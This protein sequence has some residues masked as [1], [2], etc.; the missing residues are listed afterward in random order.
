MV[1]NLPAFFR[2]MINKARDEKNYLIFDQWELDDIINTATSREF[3]IITAKRWGISNHK[4][5]IVY[6]GKNQDD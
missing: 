1:L 3:P 6:E 4:N 2:S 5:G